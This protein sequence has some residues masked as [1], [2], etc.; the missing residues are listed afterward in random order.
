MEDI[1]KLEETIKMEREGKH[2]YKVRKLKIIL[3]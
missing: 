1:W 2:Y 3:Y